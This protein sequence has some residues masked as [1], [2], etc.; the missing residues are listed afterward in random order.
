[1]RPKK[2]IKSF[3]HLSTLIGTAVLLAA[4]SGG[5]DGGDSNNNGGSGPVNN[6]DI[7]SLK[8]LA[9][10]LAD[11]AEFYKEDGYETLDLLNVNL[12]TAPQDGSCDVD[13]TTGCT[14][15]DINNDNDGSDDLKA[16]MKVHFSADDFAIDGLD[17]NATIKQRGDTSRESDQKSYAVTMEKG[18]PLW[19]NEQRLQLNKHPFDPVRIRNKISFDLMKDV[20]YM[21]SLRTQFVNLKIEDAGLVQDHGL[22]T[23]VEHVTDEYMLN[24]GYDVNSPLYKTVNFNFTRLEDRLRLNEDGS[25]ADEDR[26]ERN[27]EIKGGSDHTPLVTMLTALNDP[28]TDKSK[29]LEENFNEN[30]IVTWLAFNILVGN[31]DTVY[32]NHY[33]L[34]PLGS[35]RFYY[36]PWDYDG[37]FRTENNPDDYE[38]QSATRRRIDYGIS[39]WWQSVLIRNWLQQ[40]GS[41]ALLQTRVKE[42]YS[43]ALSAKRITALSDNYKPL[44]QPIL[45]ASPDATN[46]YGET[47]QEKLIEWFAEIEDMPGIVKT[48]HDN[49]INAAGWPMTFELN[50]AV[51]NGTISTFSWVPSWDFEGDTITY[52]LTI[53][54]NP[55][56][57]NPI[58]N[59]TV[60]NAIVKNA[61]EN[62]KVTVDIDNSNLNAGTW[63]WSVIARDDSGADTNWRPSNTRI[64]V[65]DTNYYGVSSFLIF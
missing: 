59:Q 28:E 22:F 36:L 42:L 31:I 64:T 48:N 35:N 33:I 12:V 11:D 6:I 10:D 34:N 21:N 9:S 19:R 20:A 27:L 29:I 52:D 61:G 60:A 62:A 23:H 2:I 45:M 1:M 55:D 32:E 18:L 5:G 24:R 30:N 51:T 41:Y 56:M 26:F 38:G 4:C 49:F 13:D 54:D 43:G 65:N 3:T 46:L 58:L 17:Y 57:L 7:T 25:P 14:F 47:D 8:P 53:A 50:D 44:I 40:E 39:K 15:Q 16:K 63:Y 37:A